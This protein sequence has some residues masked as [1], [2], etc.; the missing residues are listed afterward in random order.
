MLETSHLE[1]MVW[2]HIFIQFDTCHICSATQK[3]RSFH[4]FQPPPVADIAFDPSPEVLTRI[5]CRSSV[6]WEDWSPDQ[7]VSSC[8]KEKWSGR[9][10]LRKPLHL[11]VLKCS[12]ID[13]HLSR[14]SLV[15]SFFHVALPYL[16][17]QVTQVPPWRLLLFVVPAYQGPKAFLQTDSIGR[18]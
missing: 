5:P 13:L 16:P 11:E 15:W 8:L 6:H 9:K 4:L 14:W 17:V 18:L 10:S 12:S 2:Q 7:P 3:S 1:P